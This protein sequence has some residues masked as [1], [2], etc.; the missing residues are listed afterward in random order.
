VSH[1]ILSVLLRILFGGLGGSMLVSAM[2]NLYSRQTH[3]GVWITVLVGLVCL[4]IAVCPLSWLRCV[5]FWL[6]LTAI[7]AIIVVLAL[8]LSVYIYGRSDTATHKEDALI[9]L[10]CRVVG[11]TPTRSLAFRLDRAIRYH[12]RNP[13]AVIVVSGGKGPDEGCSEAEAMANYLMDAGVPATSILQED[14]STSTKENFALSKAVLDEHFDRPYTVAFVSNDYHI[15]RSRLIGRDNG[16]KEITYV[17]AATPIGTFYSSGF[18]EL[19]AIVNYII[20]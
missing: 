4:I 3:L 2:W 10:G 11:T 12:Q 20:T 7:L 19:C 18:R 8:F 1:P 17:G 9:V 16:F 15:F 6:R 13:D 5:P 14:R